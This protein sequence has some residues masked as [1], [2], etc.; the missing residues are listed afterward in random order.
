MKSSFSWWKHLIW[1]IYNIPGGK[2]AGM[3]IRIHL[4]YGRKAEKGGN[5][6]NLK[7]YMLYGMAALYIVAGINH[8]VNPAGYIKILP[9]RLPYPG[10]IIIISGICEILFALFLLP[11]ITRRFAA[12]AIILLLIAIFPANLQMTMNY[13]NTNNPGLWLTIL[14][15]PLQG[16]LIYWAY[17]YTK[18]GSNEF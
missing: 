18:A 3:A 7:N 15:L 17:Q 2:D 12:W 16:L 14:R 5:D 9:P 1:I 13:Y 4:M 10:L 8:F 6:L 11:V